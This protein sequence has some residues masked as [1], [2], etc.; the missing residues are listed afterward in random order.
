[1]K[2][3]LIRWIINAGA[4]FLAARVVEGIEITGF[5]PA[6]AGA[7]IL[8]I[9]NTFIRPVVLILTLPLNIL[10]LGLLTFIINGLMLKI[11][12]SILKGFEVQGF[13]PAVWGALIISTV[14]W[15]MNIFVNSRGKIEHI[16]M[17]K[18]RDGQWE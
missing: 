3:I 6:L 16:E 5:L 10:T 18:G 14:S 7:L 13:G 11:V 2:G 9:L 1:M 15:I 17:K 4:L 8:G 12:A